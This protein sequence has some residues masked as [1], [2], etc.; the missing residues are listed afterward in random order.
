MH[1][2]L[3]LTSCMYNYQTFYTLVQT[4]G[5]IEAL[6]L[7]IRLN[8]KSYIPKGMEISSILLP[9]FS[10]CVFSWSSVMAPS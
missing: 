10:R 3:I 2:G 5:V 6:T 7:S 9:P 1:A 4:N 8:P